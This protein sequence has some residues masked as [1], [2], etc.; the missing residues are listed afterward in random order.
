MKIIHICGSAIRK[1][2]IFYHPLIVLLKFILMTII[3]IIRIITIPYLNLETYAMN[4]QSNF[5]D[6]HSN[7]IT[8]TQSSKNF[9]KSLLAVKNPGWYNSFKYFLILKAKGVKNYILAAR[10]LFYCKK[11]SCN[12]VSNVPKISSKKLKQRKSAK[13]HRKDITD[14]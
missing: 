2:K 14:F 12:K 1:K 7:I 5:Y 10:I 9:L 13:M 6:I 8:I 11:C 4:L 3:I